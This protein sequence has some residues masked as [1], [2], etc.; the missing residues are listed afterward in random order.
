MNGV[1]IINVHVYFYAGT[2]KKWCE[3]GTIE[4][5]LTR[6]H[7][8]GPPGSGKTCT[9][10][11]LLNKDP[12]KH[13]PR[14][15]TDHQPPSNSHTLSDH[16]P[17]AHVITDMPSDHTPSLLS[18]SITK[19]TPIACKA[20]KALR[21]SINNDDEIW[22]AVSRNDLLERLASDLKR[23]KNELD[24]KVSQQKKPRLKS[25]GLPSLSS[26]ESGSDGASAASE[27]SSQVEF[28][29]ENH[30]SEEAEHG[31]SEEA[32]HSDSEEAVHSNSEEAEHGNSE[33]AVH[34]DSEDVAQHYDS[35][36]ILKKIVTLIPE[37]KAQLSD[38][39]V[40]IVDSGGQPA[41]QELLPLFTRAASLNII[42]IDLSKNLDDKFKFTYRING[43]E[44]ECDEKMKYSNREL[45]KFAV[46]SDTLRK[47]LNLSYEVTKLPQHSM[48]FV[49]GTH[50]DILVKEFGE[51][52]AKKKVLQMSE[53]LMSPLTLMPYLT[54]YI[55]SNV[56]SNS[57]I[58]PVNTLVTNSKERAQASKILLNTISDRVEV[59][60]TVKL[61][62]RC[63]TFELFLE[64]KAESKGFLTRNEAVEEGKKLY[65][66]EAD[67]DEALAYLH[68]C[69][70]IL[71]YPE[72]EPK[73]VFFDPQRILDVLSHLLALTYVDN[74]SAQ[75][76]AM[77]I[78]QKEI[79][80]LKNRG[81][82]QEVLLKKFTEA[83]YEEFQPR[84]FINLLKHLHIIAEFEYSNGE[85]CYFLPSVLPAYDNSFNTKA[86]VKPLLFVWIKYLEIESC[87]AVP[88]PQGIFH[89]IVVQLLTQKEYKV[90]FPSSLTYHC[91]YRDAIML[92]IFFN[93][94]RYTL[95]IINCS[96]HIEVHFIGNGS[97]VYSP[98]VCEL[99]TTAV[100]KSSDSISVKHDHVYAFP[101]L[102]ASTSGTNENEKCYCIVDDEEKIANCTLCPCPANISEEDRSYWCWFGMDYDSPVVSSGN[103]LF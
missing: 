91:K 83:F 96:T 79:V 75:S 51:I 17:P 47:P 15:T 53:E 7:M 52:M 43:K 56:Q 76:F 40:Y 81:Y 28:S 45:F 84:Y 103:Q 42:T 48:N 46:S 100:N 11:L 94:K 65:M 102:N 61:P 93:R 27:E 66:S 71:Y 34:S 57:M 87:V 49:V 88:V 80:N 19:S 78:E 90:Q 33:E 6:V 8:V 41:Y 13:D 55:I 21:V 16:T 38:K 31:N 36:S 35:G 50:Y 74:R 99:L 69:T 64:S 82:F 1:Y 97:E 25:S 58:V 22:E 54:N 60:L 67:V 77:G 86:S 23:I 3:E 18:K 30:D 20:V 37:A 89:L 26:Q 24:C 14:P 98:Q 44:F 9:Q 39:W 101:C 12:P 63:I 85:V 68:N 5:T 29:A 10:C 2:M 73:L 4:L 95:Q 70:I 32:E 72:V 59:S 62:I 92:W